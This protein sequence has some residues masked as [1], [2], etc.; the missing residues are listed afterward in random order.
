MWEWLKNKN[1]IPYFEMVTPQGRA[2]K[3]N[4]IGIDSQQAKELF[5]RIQEIDREKFDSNW[6]PQP[7]L[8]G[9]ECLRH[10]YSC[11][12]NANGD[13]QPCVGVTIAVGN[14]R[15][16]KLSDIIKNS[17]VI[18]EL[19]NYKKNIKGPCRQC[20]KLEKCYGCR[21]TAYQLTGDYLASDPSCWNNVEK[22][23]DIVYLPTDVSNLLPH[24]LP[25]RIVDRLLSIEEKRTVTEVDV[26]K[27][28]IFVSEEGK[29]DETAY[30][31]IIAQSL[32]AMKGFKNLSNG[33]SLEG[34]LLG[35]KRMKIYDSA[36]VGDKLT[37]SIYKVGEYENITIVRGEI[38]KDNKLIAEGEI[39]TWHKV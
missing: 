24:K 33:K 29:L 28:K 27:D 19:R 26:S 5:Y 37:S 15:E 3:N 38:F 8:V 11:V 14:V 4:S 20:D 7:P 36:V 2:K 31:E 17:E 1:I 32:A 12:V 16:K 35:A 39:K 9:G 13:V 22:L 25:M 23:D 6:A 18:Q 10:L 21:G 34:F 30:L